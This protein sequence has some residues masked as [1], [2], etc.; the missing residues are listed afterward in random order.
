M[1]KFS[2]NHTIY[3]GSGIWN[4]NNS[5]YYR[6]VNLERK[7]KWEKLQGSFLMEYFELIDLRC[8]QGSFLVRFFIDIKEFKAFS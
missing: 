7:I 1:R 8:C 4:Q 5:S 3:V 6:R 2:I